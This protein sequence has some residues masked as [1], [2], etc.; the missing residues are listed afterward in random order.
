MLSDRRMASVGKSR[1]SHST[2]RTNS[3][4]GPC[5]SW[6]S[7][8]STS[9]LFFEVSDKGPRGHL[10]DL[11]EIYRSMLSDLRSALAGKSRNSHSTPRTNST[12]GPRTSW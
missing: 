8:T 1:N 11:D 5:T 10:V 4:E 3:T 9:S 12:E 7:A 6:Y 2:P